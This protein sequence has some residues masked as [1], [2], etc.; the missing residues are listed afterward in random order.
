MSR[1]TLRAFL[2]V[3]LPSEL[4]RLA[5]ARAARLRLRLGSQVRWVPEENLHLTLK[6]LGD[7]D[8]ERVPVLVRNAQ[9]KL[10]RQKPFSVA[11]GGLGSFPD[12]RRARIIWLGVSRGAAELARLARRLDAAAAR[13]GVERERRPYRAHLTLGRL[14]QPSAIP[15]AELAPAPDAEPPCF[16][17]SE[18]VLYES[19]LSPSGA[20]HV[21]LAHLLLQEVDA[22]QSEFAPES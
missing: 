3:T 14:R 1:E 9:A 17:V 19:R 7:I 20:S 22:S 2:A 12:A 5:L 16:E 10:G 21:P 15:L 11:L 18:V 8:P 6:F 13:I 4:R